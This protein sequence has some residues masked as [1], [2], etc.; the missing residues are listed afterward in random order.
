[1]AARVWGASTAERMG[2]PGAF[3]DCGKC[4]RPGEEG[5][6]KR[7]KWGCDELAPL[8]VFTTGCSRCFGQAPEDDP[9]PDCSHGV[10][11]HR[12]CPSALIAEA[13]AKERNAATRAFQAYMALEAHGLPPVAGGWT[14]QA[15]GF[16]QTCSVVN[17]ERGRYN[18]ILSE[19][20]AQERQRRESARRASQAKSKGGRR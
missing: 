20:Q 10:I 12:R 17:D 3:P 6:A 4:R 9:C 15:V 8:P 14:E 13:D 11:E 16:H 18:D 19:H 7:R 2:K 5:R 1:M